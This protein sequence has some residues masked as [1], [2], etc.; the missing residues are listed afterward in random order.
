MALIIKATV[1]NFVAPKVRL[2]FTSQNLQRGALSDTVGSD[3]SQ[4]LTRAWS[5]QTV[6]FEC[7]GGVSV[8][9]LRF[10]VGG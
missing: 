2:Q 6:K 3:Q 10:Q 5:R 7:I 9:Y 4:D 1:T 8:G